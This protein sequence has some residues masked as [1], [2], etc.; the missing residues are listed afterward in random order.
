MKIEGGAALRIE[1]L[2]AGYGHAKVIEG[3]S[4]PPL[5]PGEMVALVGPNAA[6]KS[7]LLR[8]IACLIPSRGTLLHGSTDLRRLSMPQRA[9]LVGFMP[10]G[11]LAGSSLTVLESLVAA[12]RTIPHKALSATDRIDEAF[13]VLDRLGIL[14]LAMRPV[15]RLSGGQ[16]QVASLAFCIAHKPSILLLDEPTS[17]LDLARQFQIMR[18]IREI[19]REGRIGLVVLHDLALA[20]QWADRIAVFHHGAVYTVDRP[21]EAITPEMLKEIY[22]IEA[23][24]ERC[25]QGRLQIMTDGISPNLPGHSTHQENAASWACS[26]P[27]PA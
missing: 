18:L 10:Q 11:G 12:Q 15:E 27:K 14:H 8:S 17:A 4:L 19:V 21:D 1:D 2:E 9:A 7:T 20:A 23:R 16:Q 26:S 3:L 6:G 24:I 13:E 25:S 5:V 22:G